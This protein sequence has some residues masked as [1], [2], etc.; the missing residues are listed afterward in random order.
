M[1]GMAIRNWLVRLMRS[2]LLDIGRILAKTVRDCGARALRQNRAAGCSP[3]FAGRLSASARPTRSQSMKLH[4]ITRSGLAGNDERALSRSEWHSA[5]V[6]RRL[7]HPDGRYAPP[8]CSI[9]RVSAA[10]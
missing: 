8:P 7:L 10:R 2:L 5:E 6:S 3:V 4:S 9:A 1:F